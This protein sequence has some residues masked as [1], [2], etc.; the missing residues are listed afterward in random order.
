[1]MRGGI[2]LRGNFW[3][4]WKPQGERTKFV[5]SISPVLTELEVSAEQVVA[6]GQEE[7]YPIVVARIIFKGGSI[8]SLVRFR[9]S[10][11]ERELIAAGVPCQES[12]ELNA[13]QITLIWTP[14]TILMRI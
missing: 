12:V 14:L 3:L 8:S 4:I 11:K 7:Y 5:D 13:K 10:D 6:L 1:M 2:N 9:F